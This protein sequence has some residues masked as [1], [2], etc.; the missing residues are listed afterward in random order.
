MQKHFRHITPPFLLLLVRSLAIRLNRYGVEPQAGNFHA[1][2]KADL[3]I[4]NETWLSTND[5]G[6]QT[7]TDKNRRFS[8]IAAPYTSVKK[9]VKL[10]NYLLPAVVVFTTFFSSACFRDT[11]KLK[12]METYEGP[13][14]VS[15]NVHILLSSA[16]QVKIEM[17]GAK[18]LQYQDGDFEFPEGLKII[19]YDKKGDQK[20]QLTAQ[21]GYFI[22]KENLYRATGD[23]VI[24]DLQQRKTLSTEELFW[25]PRKKRFY[26]DQF[27]TIETD[28][29]L[30]Q[31]T[32][33]ESTEDF[34]S[35]TIKQPRES[36]L[37]FSES[38][39]KL[40]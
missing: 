33:F 27:L 10:F 14:M 2:G 17:S 15:E 18:Q 11:Q 37:K 28:S 34:S 19:F 29:T 5:T 22:K 20:S 31:G 30:I 3:P 6:K 38:N 32:G 35:Y 13:E 24:K 7:K 40:D 8:E 25:D 4:Q 39:E 16:A 26:N 21:N 23:V 12:D 36:I 9:K 1:E